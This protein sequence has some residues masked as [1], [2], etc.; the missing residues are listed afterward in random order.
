MCEASG[1][2][3]FIIQKFSVLV[4]LVSTVVVVMQYT[5]VVIP[6]ASGRVVVNSVVP[7][8]SNHR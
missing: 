2:V 4:S 5:V 7:E 1:P 6:A 8:V 3:A